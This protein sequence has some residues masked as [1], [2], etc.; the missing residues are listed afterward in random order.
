MNIYKEI[1]QLIQYGL[2]KNMISLWDVDYIRNALLEVFDLGAAEPVTI[3]AE[4]LETPIDILKKMLDYAVEKRLIPDDT[5]TQRDLF[6][7]KIMGRLVPRPGEVIRK[8][9]DLYKRAGP[10]E[11]TDYFYELSK[12]S[13]YIRT[14]RIA[15]NVSWSSATSYG[16]LEITINLSKPEKDPKA[17][18][19]AKENASVSYPKCLLCKE[20]VGYAGRLDHPAR[21]NHRIIPIELSGQR[22]F[23][24]Y[25]PYVYYNE[26]AIVFSEDHSPMKISKEGFERLLHFVKQ[27]PHYFVGSNADLPIVGGSILS[28][29]HF[30]AGRHPFPM[31][32]AP[33]EESMDF[34]DYP[35]IKV[36]KVKWPMSVIRLQGEDKE[37]IADLAEKILH[38]WKAYDDDRLDIVSE[39]DGTPHNTITP[40]A[41][42]REGLFELDLVL[43]NN[44]TSTAH[45]MGIFHPHEEV[46]HIKKENIGLIEVMGLAVLPGRLVEEMEILAGY[47]LENELETKAVNDE[48]TSKHVDWAKQIIAAHQH[49]DEYNIKEVLKQE[50]GRTF[51]KVLEHAGVFKRTPEGQ[52]GF[53]R[54]LKTVEHGRQEELR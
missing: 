2:Q 5:V 31:E 24:Q 8:F 33:I 50:I 38:S 14:D 34:G 22:W 48:R 7:T 4:N 27:F 16:D 37:E 11:A 26:H 29:D 9:Y 41:R 28:H 25:S 23:L 13:H 30:Q 44:Q 12:S 52:E 43:R 19:A 32:K 15:K 36:G 17:I 10:E 6:D 42:V 1:E 46:H 51:S 39:T 3:E 40:I 21:Q 18:A 53:R 20:N 35:G 49:L 47:M 54:F 45:P